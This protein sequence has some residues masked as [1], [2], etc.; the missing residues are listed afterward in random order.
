[1]LPVGLPAS[2]LA[3][4]GLVLLGAVFIAGGTYLLGR[5]HG[6]DACEQRHK[7]ALAESLQRGIE[8]AQDIARQDAEVSEFYQQTR[9]RIIHTEPKIIEVVK[10]AK[11]ADDTPACHLSDD[12]FRLL[13]EARGYGP[14]GPDNP[15]GVQGAVPHS[16]APD[17][18]AP[19]RREVT[20]LSHGPRLQR[21]RGEDAATGWGG[22]RS[23]AI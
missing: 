8:Q 9:T 22:Q 14:S 3:P 16:P 21:L 6:A 12:E 17:I 2:R 23:G 20:P 5:G 15:G 18:K 13:N 11:T 1:M 19:Q 4:V 7:A 10:H